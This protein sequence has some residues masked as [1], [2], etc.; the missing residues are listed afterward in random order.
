M[1]KKFYCEECKCATEHERETTA[2]V[3]HAIMTILFFAWGIIWAACYYGKKFKCTKC[4]TLQ[5]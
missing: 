5:K 3:F 1:T 2:H 4:D